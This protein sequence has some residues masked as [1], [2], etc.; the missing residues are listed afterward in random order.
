MTLHVNDTVPLHFQHYQL[1]PL[2]PLRSL[3]PSHTQTCVITLKRLDLTTRPIMEKGFACRGCRARKVRCTDE[4]PVCRTVSL[5]AHC[6]VPHRMVLQKER[7]VSY[8]A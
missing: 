3:S 2:V 1:R 8:S 4:L 5:T 6:R 7:L